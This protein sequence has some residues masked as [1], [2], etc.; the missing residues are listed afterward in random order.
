[1]L[2]HNATKVH[3][4]GFLFFLGGGDDPMLSLEVVGWFFFRCP[5]FQGD[6]PNEKVILL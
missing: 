3:V 2:L 5:S 1:M 4:S 6:I